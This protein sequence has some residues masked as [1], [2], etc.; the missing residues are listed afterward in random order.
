[1]YS[2][3]AK[4]MVARGTSAAPQPATGV[5]MP[6]FLPQVQMQLMFNRLTR[7]VRRYLAIGDELHTL[8]APY[9]EFDPW[10]GSGESKLLGLS[11]DQ[12][13]AIQDLAIQQD[14]IEEGLCSLVDEL[15]AF[16]TCWGDEMECL[17]TIA[18]MR[19]R[20][21][22][23][24]RRDLPNCVTDFFS[25]N[26]VGRYPRR[27]QLRQPRPRAGLPRPPQGDPPGVVIID[28]AGELVKE[29]LVEKLQR[30]VY[31]GKTPP[32]SHDPASATNP[33]AETVRT[34]AEVP[35]ATAL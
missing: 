15:E 33:R 18:R 7:D 19:L 16:E 17:T 10:D 5:G 30:F 29:F 21:D 25:P 12:T 3:M 1:M 34:D 20:R 14:L 22:V 23:V 11:P 6:G 2:G 24:A 32:S 28:A 27:A 26:P 9:V 31:R 8:K 13:K 35:E 4:P